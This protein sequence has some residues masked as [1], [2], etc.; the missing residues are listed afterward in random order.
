M[1]DTGINALKTV[2]EKVRIANKIVKRKPVIDEYSRNVEEIMLKLLHDSTASQFV[3]K[4]WIEV[5]DLSYG[6]YSVNKY[7]WFKLQ[8]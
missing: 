8:C 7:I 4:K 1:L 5:S 2:S 3:T 6:Q